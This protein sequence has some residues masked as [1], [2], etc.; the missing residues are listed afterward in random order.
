MMSIIFTVLHI[1]DDR[2][3]ADED[4]AEADD[5]HCDQVPIASGESQKGLRCPSKC[6]AGEN[7][8]EK[9]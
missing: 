9:V 8:S 4:E 6:Q 5:I 7:H 2:S 3:A 1:G